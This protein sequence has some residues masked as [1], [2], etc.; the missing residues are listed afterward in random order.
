[1]GAI[2]CGSRQRRQN[3]GIVR[4]PPVCTLS[5]RP[6]SVSPAATGAQPENFDRGPW[7][8]SWKSGKLHRSAVVVSHFGRVGGR[9][10]RAIRYP[11]DLAVPQYANWG[12]GRRATLNDAGRRVRCSASNVLAFDR[13]KEGSCRNEEKKAGDWPPRILP[14]Y[15]RPHYRTG[16]T[17][18]SRQSRR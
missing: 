14:L 9:G 11:R 5:A 1:L 7:C 12:D 3:G 18:G 2:K 6:R 13:C 17:S 15:R 4:V 16:G 10:A 8:L